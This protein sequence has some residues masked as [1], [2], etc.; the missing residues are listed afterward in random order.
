MEKH[1]SDKKFAE[2]LVRQANDGHGWNKAPDMLRE[3]AERITRLRTILLALVQ[4]EPVVGCDDFHHYKSDIG[5]AYVMCPPV[6]RWKKAMKEAR[7]AISA[8]P[9]P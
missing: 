5:H 9:A 1:V 4:D 2:R 8:E 7:A 6:E 3:A